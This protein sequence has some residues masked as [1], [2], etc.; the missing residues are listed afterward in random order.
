MNRMVSFMTSPEELNSFFA[1]RC[2]TDAVTEEPMLSM[3]ASM[4]MDTMGMGTASATP[5]SVVACR[6]IGDTDS[7]LIECVLII[8]RHRHAI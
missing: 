2:Y 1:N 4:S 6:P 5:E 8:W 7:S 3:Y